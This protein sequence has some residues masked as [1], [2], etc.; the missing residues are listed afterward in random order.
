[1][2][3]LLPLPFNLKQTVTIRVNERREKVPELI[4]IPSKLTIHQLQ[5]TFKKMAGRGDSNQRTWSLTSG[6]G[7]SQFREEGR[8]CHGSEGWEVVELSAASVN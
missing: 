1:M 2:Y 6:K 8:R 5:E 3:L 4:G 7:N